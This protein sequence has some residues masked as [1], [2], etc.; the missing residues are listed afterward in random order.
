[1]IKALLALITAALFA[2]GC[3]YVSLVEHS[4][5]M[6]IGDGAAL[7]Q[8]KESARRAR[9]LQA[10]LALVSFLIGLWAWWK[11]G[12]ICLLAGAV[13]VGINIPLTLIA[14]LPTNRRL[15]AIAPE[16][17]GAESRVLLSRWGKLHA[18]RTG[19]GLAAVVFYFAAFL[20]P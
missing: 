12:D 10:G 13:L 11:V 14:I 19:L 18:L 3:L 15:E 17:A 5:R 7:A 8:F 20:E 9:I 2:G 6:R 1:M 4:A 16:A